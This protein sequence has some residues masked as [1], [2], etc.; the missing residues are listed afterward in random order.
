MNKNIKLLIISSFI[1][2]ILALGVASSYYCY[3]PTESKS[4]QELKGKLNYEIYKYERSQGFTEE[5]LK[6]KAKDFNPCVN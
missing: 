1:V 4:T 5:A 6:L 2:L 3:N